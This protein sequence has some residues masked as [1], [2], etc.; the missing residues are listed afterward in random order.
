MPDHQLYIRR[1]LQLAALGDANVAPNPMVGSVLVYHDRIIGEGYH[2]Q[3][4]SPHAEVNCINSV[5]ENDRYLV[6]N[7]TLYVS[8]EP[9]AHYGKTP[10]CAD[11]IIAS[12]IKK[13]VVGCRDSFEKVDGKG[14]EKLKHAGVE[15][16]MNVLEE[17]C[18]SLNKKFF[19]FHER[20]R[21]Y[22]TLKWAE[23]ADGKI[24]KTGE[25]LLISNDFSDRFVHLLRSQH[26]AILVGC[27][28]VIADDPAL[29]VRLVPGSS[30]V[31]LVIDLQRKIPRNARIFNAG[32]T[33]IFTETNHEPVSNVEFVELNK[34]N[35]IL[36]QVL[37]Y[38]FHHQLQSILVEGGAITLQHFIDESLW[39]EA[40]VIRNTTM[41]AG[42]G[43]A[44]PVL[45][46][47]E[48]LATQDL[49]NDLITFYKRQVHC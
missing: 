33:I 38:C 47:G 12:G 22:I 28:T 39:D 35:D 25:R 19:V 20:K 37:Q 43:I 48:I 44:S 3:Y 16:V 30:P 24:G 29:D 17:E 26:M 21:P 2:Q 32:K 23:T 13:V 8:L 10:P 31:K 46:N 11:L 18:K 4:G 14:I 6:K 34:S 41:V 36:Q 40:V 49:K 1:C 27:K 45:A 7:S 5:A 15:V 9:C 42:A